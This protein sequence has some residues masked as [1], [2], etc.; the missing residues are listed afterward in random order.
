MD[1]FTFDD[2][3]AFASSVQ[4]ADVDIMIRN[5]GRRRWTLRHL[6]AAGVH[7]QQ[8]YEGSGGIARGQSRPDG[9]LLF[10]PRSAHQAQRANGVALQKNTITILEP[11][12]EFCL[13][14]DC[15]HQWCTVFIPE[16]QLADG[17]PPRGEK[18]CVRHIA[19]GAA[20]SY[21]QLVDRIFC[22]AEASSEIIANSGALD[23]VM[24][25]VRILSSQI[26][27]ASPPRRPSGQGGRPAIPRDEIV[28]RLRR[29]VDSRDGQTL[30]LR[31]ILA[32]CEVSERTL[33]S[34]F[35]DYFGASPRK[36]LHL[37]Q[38]HQVRRA[39]RTARS[40]NVSVSAVLARFGVWEF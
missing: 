24:S 22:A 25:D 32:A 23:G 12:S 15:D 34:V 11:G 20:Q 9:Y 37:R 39:L 19:H 26:I 13:T 3:D 1:S 6:E 7:F 4:D 35:H 40:G 16:A 18:P 21:L 33:R 10:L 29:L 31:E 5:P 36:F 30:L 2:F 17:A 27:G 14:A 8:G 28:R 38:L